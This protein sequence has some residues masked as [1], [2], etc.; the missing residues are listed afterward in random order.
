MQGAYH[1][2]VLAA[3]RRIGVDEA[4]AISHLATHAAVIGDNSYATRE[5]AAALEQGGLPTP[6]ILGAENVMEKNAA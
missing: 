4:V 6:T 3:S 5:L 1:F 2:V